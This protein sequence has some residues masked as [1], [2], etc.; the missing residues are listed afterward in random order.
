MGPGQGSTGNLLSV[1]LASRSLPYELYLSLLY[2]HC[3]SHWWFIQVERAISFWANLPISSDTAN[4][5]AVTPFNKCKTKTVKSKALG[6]TPKDASASNIKG[7]KEEVF[8]RIAEF[9]ADMW[10]EV[11]KEWIRGA[12]KKGYDNMLIMQPLIDAAMEITELKAPRHSVPDSTGGPLSRSR[13]EILEGIFD[14][15][16]DSE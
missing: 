10:S 3:D 4:E 15:N 12:A 9:N 16:L 2:V 14:P 7:K 1:L 6:C 11:T 13:C 8:G 5:K